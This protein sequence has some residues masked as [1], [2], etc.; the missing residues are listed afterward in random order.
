MADINRRA[1]LAGTAAT[2]ILATGRQISANDVMTPV[3]DL[4]GETILIT[5]CSS[6]FGRLMAEG[7]AR[8][9]AKVFAT[10]RNLPRIKSEELM[11]LAE[12]ERLDLHVRGI[13]VP[14]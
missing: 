11:Q 13:D 14:V 10:M 5:G 6:G 12:D 8:K 9:K 4:S 2:G 1:L 3:S 7:F